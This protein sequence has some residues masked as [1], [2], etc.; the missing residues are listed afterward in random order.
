MTSSDALLREARRLASAV[1]AD[2]DL[3][4]EWQAYVAGSKAELIRW[5]NA[6]PDNVLHQMN[7]EE[8]EN[9]RADLAERAT[10]TKAWW[11]QRRK[12]M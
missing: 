4:Q 8:L 6:D 1:G 10:E 3:K 12:G 2:A 9:L 11:I 7:D 5:L